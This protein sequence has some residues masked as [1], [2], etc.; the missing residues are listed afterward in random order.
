MPKSLMGISANGCHHNISL[1]QGGE[2]MFMPDT[3]NPRMPS[4]LGLNAIGGV[5]EHLAALTCIT[6]PTVNSYR[7]VFETR[8]FAPLVAGRGFHKPHPTPRAGPPRRGLISAAGLPGDP[9][10]FLPAP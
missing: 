7:R 5:L 3:D 9:H 10:P 1:W 4:K 6:A 8:V 2:N